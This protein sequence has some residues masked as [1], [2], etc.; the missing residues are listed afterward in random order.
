MNSF[1]QTPARAYQDAPS[2]SPKSGAATD[3]AYS[4]QDA[5]GDQSLDLTAIPQENYIESH[6]KKLVKT[7][8]LA[9]FSKQKKLSKVWDYGIQVLDVQDKKKYFLCRLCMFHLYCKV[10]Y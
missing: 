7:E 5:E 9:Y 8:G 2:A 3:G 10:L 6:N 4:W 1:L